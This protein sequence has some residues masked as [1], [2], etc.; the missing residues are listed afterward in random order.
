MNAKNVKNTVT[1]KE[2]A[3]SVSETDATAKMAETDVTATFAT[4]QKNSNVL[5]KDMAGKNTMSANFDG[6]WLDGCREEIIRGDAVAR[7]GLRN[8]HQAARDIE[9]GLGEME[10]GLKHEFRHNRHFDDC[11]CHKHKHCGCE[12]AGLE[13]F[14]CGC[15]C[16]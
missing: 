10:H 1:N 3:V 15:G 8:L 9:C 4:L 12:C 7:V 11:G 2:D 16:H 6:I 14:G 13:K 5:A